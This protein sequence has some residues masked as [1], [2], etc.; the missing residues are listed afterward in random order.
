[1][2]SRFCATAV[3]KEKIIAVQ[4]RNLMLWHTLRDSLRIDAVL[5]DFQRTWVR[6]DYT[7]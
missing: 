7:F 3:K 6:L 1:M 4:E 2:S 5:A